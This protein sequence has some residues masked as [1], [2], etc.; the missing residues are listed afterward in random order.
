MLSKPS[1]NF[2][3]PSLYDDLELNGRLYFPRSQCEHEEDRPRGCAVFAHPYAPLGG[4]YD[5]PVVNSVGSLLVGNGFIVVTFNFRGA[6]NSAGRTSWSSKAELGD[7]VSIY[8][9]VLAIMNA[10]GVAKYLAR[11]DHHEIDQSPILLLGGYSYGS[12]IAAHL[13]DIRVVLSILQR[14]EDGSAEYEIKT[15]AHELAQA[16]LGYCETQQ[17][18]GQRSLKALPTET[19]QPSG[20]TFGGYESPSAA[21]R[22]SREGSRRSLNRERARHSVERVRR[23]LGSRG[24]GHETGTSASAEAVEAPQVTPK[25]AFLLI[26]PLVGAISSFATMFSTLRFERR[27]PKSAAARDTPVS[28][29]DAMLS[30][31]SSLVVFGTDD[32]FTSSRKVKGWCESLR[33]KPGSSTEYREVHGAGHFWHDPE[34]EAQMIESVSRW[35]KGM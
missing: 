33:A 25:L 21:H 13:P 2:T 8:A 22:I 19:L 4:C 31:N 24:N 34:L 23:K 10:S 11:S 3:L 7:Y 9:L 26:S 17:Q 5:D 14:A 1:A 32:H 15:R 28:D 6:E 16:F 12:M 27:D 30:S 18:R 35:V 20:A 29:T